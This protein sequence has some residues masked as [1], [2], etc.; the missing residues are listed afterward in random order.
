MIRKKL[1]EKNLLD[2]VIGQPEKAF[3][4]TDIPTVL[5]VKKEPIERYFIH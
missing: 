3:M 2:A 1:I 5:L 4:N